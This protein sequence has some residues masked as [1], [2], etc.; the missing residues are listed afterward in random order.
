MAA[1][2]KKTLKEQVE[3][4]KERVSGLQARGYVPF[5]TFQFDGRSTAE[6]REAIRSESIRGEHANALDVGCE[7][8]KPRSIK[9]VAVDSCGAEGRGYV[10]YGYRN[11]LPVVIAKLAQSLPTTARCLEF[12]VEL[13]SGAGTRL[14]YNL[15]VDNGNGSVSEKKIPFELAGEY[16]KRR[17]A[18]LRE[19]CL[20]STSSPSPTL[21]H[22]DGAP[23]GTEGLELNSYRRKAEDGVAKTDPYASKNY[24]NAGSLEEMLEETKQELREWERTNEEW[25]VFK[26]RTDLDL[27]TQQW[28]NDDAYYNLSNLLF[29]M[30]KGTTTTWGKTEGSSNIKKLTERPK[31]LAVDYRSNQCCRMEEMSEQLRIEHTYYA[32]KWRYTGTLKDQDKAIVAYNS[33]M[34]NKR[35][36]MLE[37]IVL[38]NQKVS[39]DK[40]NE[41]SVVAAP[42]YVPSLDSPYYPG[43]PW[44]GIFSSMIYNLADSIFHDAATERRNAANL[45]QIVYINKQ[46]LDDYLAGLN[47]GDDDDKI[48]KA[49]DEL[50]TQVK[51]FLQHKGN[52]GGALIGE[53][54]ITDKDNVIKNIEVVNLPSVT[55][56]AS[57][58]DIELIGSCIFF[59][60]GI[61]HS[62]VG[63]FGK[64]AGSTSG[65]QQRELTLLKQCQ[66]SPRQRLFLSALNFVRDWDGWT[67]KCEFEIKQY[68]LTTLDASKTG[69]KEQ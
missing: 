55:S 34:P 33:I 38:A 47:L 59:S 21:P 37:D 32:E 8:A 64:N 49:K 29:I 51:D 46:W 43:A 53:S 7:L 1:K 11:Q 67:P 19:S 23:S 36:Q 57:L 68:V 27:L 14:M 52:K 62:L 5:K 45:T 18:Q 22:T 10:E 60:F 48:E 35:W 42:V 50:F 66:L 24:D 17:I 30:E 9:T 20:T 3:D 16:L 31:I 15:V 40:L 54:F 39:G 44:W 56:K 26:K 69:V 25:Q 6:R 12:L 4:Y 13:L 63:S 28:A 58:E 2:S 61:H 65:T 41:R